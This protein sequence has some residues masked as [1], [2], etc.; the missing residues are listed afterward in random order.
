MSVSYEC[1]LL[2]GRGICDGPINSPAESYRIWCVRV[3][4]EH[5]R[6]GLGPLG[7]STD[8]K[9]INIYLKHPETWQPFDDKKIRASIPSFLSSFP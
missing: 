3:M 5:H 7:L 9:K 2:S 1:C 4:K 8:E 6:G